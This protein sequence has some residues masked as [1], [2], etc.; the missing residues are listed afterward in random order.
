MELYSIMA[1]DTEHLEQICE[2][3]RQQVESGV[4]KCPLFMIKLVP[5]GDPAIDKASIEAKDYIPFRDRLAQM[6]IPAGI[7]VQCTIGHGYSL[8]QMFGFTQYENLTDGQKQFIACPADEDFR[9]YIRN[10]LATLAALQPDVIMVDDDFRLIGGRS[11]MG[12][13]CPLHMAM[14]RESTGADIRREELWSILSDR[15]HPL[16]SAYTEAFTETQRQSLLDAAKAMRE[17]IDS[18]NPRL[19]GIF[20]CVGNT[21]EYAAEI[22]KI[23]AGEGNPPTV[24]INNGNYHPAGA[25][26]LSRIAYRCARQ[27]DVLHKNGVN[28]ILAETDTC[29]QNRYST[30]FQSLHAHF[31][32]S[33]LE[34]ANGAKHWITRLSTHE[35][36]SGKAYRKKL[37]RHAGFYRTLANLVPDITWQGC[38]IALPTRIDFGFAG[39][40]ASDG[41][42]NCVLERFGVPLYYSSAE[43]GAVCLDGP[44]EIYSDEE[45]L[46]MCRGTLVLSS[47][48]A[49][50]LCSRGFSEYLG[51]KAEPWGKIPA[52]FE[53]LETEG[54]KCSRQMGLHTLIPLDGTRTDSTV[55]HLHNGVE[56]IP[57]APGATV[58]E[59]KL[60][61]TVIC[62]AGTP[63]TRFIYTEA[64][65]FLCESRKAQIVRLLREA[66]Q[67]PLYYAGDEEVFCK[68]GLLP[69]GTRICSL[70]NIGLDPIDEIVLDVQAKIASAEILTE[71]G[72]RVPVPFREENGRLTIE[73]PMYTLE[74]VVLFLW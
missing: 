1:L 72:E 14:F 56:Q 8:N 24:R 18:V 21:T 3:I 73:H 58:Y 26:N 64:F 29:P 22:A 9:A 17:G 30:G 57:V 16:R 31:T 54:K 62:F 36:A 32:A 27:V 66:G 70:I 48:T 11:G 33:I 15:H 6:G 74:P 25:R 12:C 68:T 61:G 45:I 13:A 53:I 19:P 10:Q 60:G 59:N 44:A 5:E 28:T 41:W 65:S 4:C 20:C 23:L 43:G 50:E 46:T 2:D 42:A 34:G 67:L 55:Y 37:A 40:D 63:N 51:V 35:P 7:L 71:E 39:T 49:A 69:D 52:S 38:R 47:N